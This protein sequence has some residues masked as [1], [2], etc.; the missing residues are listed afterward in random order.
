MRSY[1]RLLVGEGVRTRRAIMD[2]RALRANRSE[3]LKGQS[4]VGLVQCRSDRFAMS[5]SLRIS[6]GKLSLHVA[7][8]RRSRSRDRGSTPPK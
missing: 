1:I 3:D 5:R 4:C 8:V 7:T 6:S 2:I